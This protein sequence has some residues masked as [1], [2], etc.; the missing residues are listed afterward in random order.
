[1][2][3]VERLRFQ[4]KGKPVHYTGMY[5]PGIHSAS[6]Q[7]SPSIFAVRLPTPALQHVFRFLTFPPLS[8]VSAGG[9]GSLPP[10][11]P[12]PPSVL[13]PTASESREVCHAHVRLTN[14]SGDPASRGRYDADRALRVGVEV[15][16]DMG[17]SLTAVTVR[18][19]AW[20]AVHYAS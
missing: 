5:H 15:R 19:Q 2:H 4:G 20:D 17:V 1:M 7:T 12:G 11:S 14:E 6:G 3:F 13:S 18:V 8:A 16:V 10:A 9:E